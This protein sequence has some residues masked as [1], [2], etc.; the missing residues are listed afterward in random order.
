MS[1]KAYSDKPILECVVK[2]GQIAKGV[3]A[4]HPEDFQKTFGNDN[5]AEKL[6]RIAENEE[7]SVLQ[8]DNFL[9]QANLRRR[10]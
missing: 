3:I 7:M 8:F 5:S 4:L 6:I 9:E 10:W 2:A 1:I